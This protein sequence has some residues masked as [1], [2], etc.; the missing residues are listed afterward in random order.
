VEFDLLRYNS[1]GSAAYL[2]NQTL[3]TFGG[4]TL[5]NQANTVTG[6]WAHYSFTGVSA[7]AANTALQFK[8]HSYWDYTELD[9]VSVVMTAVPEPSMA[10]M[11]GAG[12]VLLVRRR[13]KRPP[14]F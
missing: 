14:P 11:L 8:L 12:L 13:A 5:M 3:V 4:T 10:L 2:D 6:D 7:T 1:Y 9:N